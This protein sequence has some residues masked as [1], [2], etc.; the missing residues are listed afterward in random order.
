MLSTRISICRDVTLPCPLAL[1]RCQEHNKVERLAETIRRFPYCFRHTAS[2]TSG[3]NHVHIFFYSN[4]L[5]FLVFLS[6]RQSWVVPSHFTC[7]CLHLHQE[8]IIPSKRF[9]S[10]AHVRWQ[11]AQVWQTRSGVRGRFGPSDSMLGVKSKILSR[12]FY[13]WLLD[14]RLGVLDTQ[15]GSPSREGIR[16]SDGRGLGKASSCAYLLRLSI[17]FCSLCVRYASAG[18]E[19]AQQCS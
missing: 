8:T 16:L 2:P 15:Q 10:S 13:K 9:Q 11:S 1:S 17:I 6:C 14:I 5:I 7:M 3:M 12:A 4:T 19:N 18:I